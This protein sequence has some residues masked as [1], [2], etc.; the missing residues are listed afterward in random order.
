MWKDIFFVFIRIRL[1]LI[2][3]LKQ[4]K[5]KSKKMKFSKAIILL[6]FA[7]STTFVACKPSDADI[8]SKIEAALK[9]DPTMASTLVDVKDGVVTMTGECKDEACKASCQKAIEG[10]KGVKSITNNCTLPVVNL[11]ASVSTLLDAA[12]QKKVTD[13]LKDIKGI[14]VSFAGDKA[15]LSGTITKADRM[16]VM[17]MLGSAK[18]KSDVSKLISK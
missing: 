15:V 4:S 18:V 7:A 11:P 5:K 1:S 16:K 6:A 12:T 17:Q 13:G 8:K 10:I 2:H 14:L 3:I 9:A